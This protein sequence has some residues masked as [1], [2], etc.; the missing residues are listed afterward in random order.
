MLDSNEGGRLERLYEQL[1]EKLLDLTKKNRML[2]YAL[3]ARSKRQLQIV[4][5]VLEEIYTKLAADDASLKIVYLEEPESIP[6]EEKT[7]EF[8]DAF[9]HAK[10]SDIEYLVALEAMVTAGGDNEIAVERLEREL[11]D[12]VRA[13]LGLPPRLKRAEVNRHEHARAQGI[14]PSPDLAPANL[15]KSH[16]DGL[17]QTLKYPDELEAV[18][19]KISD[20]ARLAEQEA[21]LST[22]FLTFGFL[23]WYESDASD[24]PFFAPLLLLPVKVYS[25]KVRGKVV[26]R[27]AAREGAAE[28]N[29]SLQKFLE[30]RFDRALPDF[31]SGDTEDIGSIENYLAQV[32]AA[33]EGLKRWQVRRMLVLGHFAFSR[34]AIYED[35]K[36]ERWPSHPA[37]DPLVSILLSGFEKTAEGNSPLSGAP[38]DYSIDDPEIE[39]AA[40]ILIQDADASQHSALVDVMRSK[41][42]VIQGPPGTG[43]SQTITNIIANALAAG[44]TVLFLA[45]KQAALDV[46]KRRLDKANLG[47]FCLELHSDK[48]SPKAV[49]K[50]LDQRYQ[51]GMRK[52]VKTSVAKV[53]ATW[54]SSRSQIAEYLNALHREAEDGT[55][56]FEHIWKAIRGQSVNA[57]VHSML[58]GVSIPAALLAAPYRLQD[59]RGQLERFAAMSQSFTVTH[60]HPSESPWHV[61]PLGDLPAYDRQPMLLAIED[62]RSS[63]VRLA[64]FMDLQNAIGITSAGAADAAVEA[65]AALGDPADPEVIA[66]IP[67]IDLDGL[68]RA[69]ALQSAHL[70]AAAALAILPAAHSV[71]SQDLARAS[72]L[73]PPLALRGLG[74]LRPSEFYAHA[75][76]TIARGSAFLDAAASMRPAM[77]LLGI[78]GG[79]PAHWVD[80]AAEASLIVSKVGAEYRPWISAVPVPA[81]A[82][83]ALKAQWAALAGEEGALRAA[84]PRF[85]GQRWP[86]AGDLE[87][88]AA[89]LSKTS[90]GKLFGAI[91][92]DGKTAREMLAALGLA[93]ADTGAADVM[94]RLARHV[95]AVESFDATRAGPAIIGPAWSGMAT[96]F[97]EIDYGMK[98]R[99]FLE[100]KLNELPGGGEVSAAVVSLHPD[101]LAALA[102]HAGA[103]GAYRQAAKTLAKLIDGVALDVA[104]QHCAG[105]IAAYETL[106]SIDPDRA[107]LAGDLPIAQLAEI[108]AARARRAR[109]HAALEQSPF[110]V[111][112]RSLAPDAAGVA[113]TSVSAAWVRAV[114]SLNLPPPMREG[115]LSNAASEWR[116]TLRAAAGGYASLHQAHRAAAEA[117][118][119]FGLPGVAAAGLHPL[120]ASLDC[121]LERRDELAEFIELRGARRHLESSGLADFLTKADEARLDPG[122]LQDAFD[123]A[124]ARLRAEAARRSSTPLAHGTGTGL[125]ANRKIFAARDRQK[126]IADR[127]TVRARLLAKE[128]PAGLR[129]GSIKTWTQLY[130]LTNEFP[131]QKR[132]TPVRALLG[133]AGEAAQALKPCFMMSP[134]SLAKFLPPETL[135]FDVLVIDE[136]SQMRPEDALGAMLRAKQIVVVG[137]P[138]QLPPTSFFD[139]SAD[140]TAL[141]DEDVDDID[142]ESILERC[143]KVFG[144]V[145]RLK[146]HYRSRCESLIR[147]SN[148]V[149]YEGSLITFP[150]AKPG[151]FSI[152]LLRV[153]GAYQ[154]RRNVAE[155][156]RVAEEAAIFMRHYANSPEESIPTLG[157][158]AVNTDQRDLIQETLRRMSSGDALVEMYKE[159]VEKKGES[160]FVKNLENVQGDERDFIFISMTYGK[161][162]R[163]TAMKQRFGPINSK[164]GH[165]RL[166][167]LF[168]RARMRIGLFT[169]FGSADIKPTQTSSEGVH[170][171]KQYLEYAEGRGRAA[172]QKVGGTADSDFEVAV[173]ERLERRSYKVDKQVGVSGFKI[174]LGV[175]HPDHPEMFLAGIECDGASYHSS[176]S[177]RDRDRL[178]EE[179]LKGLGWDILRVWSTD[180]FDNANSQT[181]KLI[182]RLEELRAKPISA[183]SDYSLK[184]S[185][186]PIEAADAAEETVVVVV[187]DVAEAAQE[188]AAPA[189][190]AMPPNS[191]EAENHPGVD[192]AALLEGSGPLTEPEAHKAL[193]A[194]R[195]TVIRPTT[196]NWEPRRSILRDG[197]IETFVSQRITDPDAWF[198]LVPQYQ[199][200]GT[201]PIEKRLYLEQICDIIER[202]GTTSRLDKMPATEFHFT[203]LIV[204]EAGAKEA[205]LSLQGS[206][207]SQAE[208]GPDNKA[209]TY[210]HADFD[211]IGAK[212]RRDAFYEAAYLPTLRN[213]VS[214]VI[215][216]E[217]PIYGDIVAVRIARAHGMERTGATIQQTVYNAVDKRVLRT[218]EDER[219]V[220]WPEAM[221]TD[222]PVQYRAS[223]EDIRSH[224]DTPLAELASLALPYLRVKLSDEHILE[225]MTEHFGMARLR[226]P[227]RRRFDA[228]IQMARLMFSRPSK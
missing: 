129:S 85:T 95:R 136:A 63:A 122:R 107:L 117:L 180:W 102:D 178:R 116:Q 118:A 134:L 125:E 82:F 204:A 225:K 146:W 227:T 194:L 22:L 148:D 128:A 137:D 90:L 99:H 149:F 9:E 72:K 172:V 30:S 51:L 23:E 226:A 151:S 207:A 83:E 189:P 5:E 67:A 192:S 206:A 155:A 173:A 220:F 80:A 98:L 126:I 112:L 52:A 222:R 216:A 201:N 17:L 152:D 213:L 167:V 48:A 142:D 87:A 205:A 115:L 160:L 29:V 166:N 108:D 56:P 141:E 46:V 32:R 96:P 188:P 54:A 16:T 221:R 14:D 110:L 25:E 39:K 214:H 12:R 185:Y 40:P 127:E 190:H 93:A 200:A 37:T 66:L 121:L 202:I 57:D 212:P 210:T 45:E 159:K 228:A 193:I 44:K 58:S 161:E 73:C 109:A 62:Y 176:K 6:P 65:D 34:I 26:Y 31:V 81:D 50:S 97:D 157:I 195:E 215:E 211:M 186:A 64:D 138:K 70:A 209:R 84:V 35:T 168:S 219:D 49:V 20:E 144:N 183:Y 100:A 10:V 208:S 43:K 74:A 114:K 53:D 47:D 174:D 163:A 86:A 179:V 198:T 187:S 224:A 170:V 75:A 68:D 139:R 24:K 135:E 41:N 132:F 11:R 89:Q 28:K 61:T 120:I 111:A 36:P 171:L 164:Q 130:M 131:K 27:I 124:A 38:E 123:T 76:Q 105:E 91:R 21:G 101:Q 71:A 156:E 197:M 196:A 19:E 2:N 113:R 177:A 7:Q 145:R 3:G 104:I 181:D 182:K 150:A 154:A 162:P 133:R 143:Q 8:I 33:I 165:R 1:R 106:L 77:D 42:L 217:G 147:F 94:Q 59:I 4:D 13:A 55:T 119:P 169:S 184:A 140:N 78:G 79:D 88:A 69:L 191:E 153:D 203:A 158:V 103:S 223:A 92:G 18:M 15:K 60:G 175:R 218:R 199:R